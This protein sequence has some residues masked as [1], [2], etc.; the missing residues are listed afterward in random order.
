V[1]TAQ[2]DF[3][4]RPECVQEARRFT[5]ETLHDWD[6][7]VVEWVAGQVVSELCTNAVLHAKTPFRIELLMNS[8]LLT[9]RVHDASAARLPVIR[10]FG[11]Q[12]TTGRG[13]ALVADLSEQWGVD[14]ETGGKTV[15]CTL[16][17]TATGGGH[18]DESSDLDLEALLDSFDEQAGDHDGRGAASTQAL[19]A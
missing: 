11:D 7:D 5:R 16:A 17:L 15:W 18:G 8:S 10:R 1:R 12:A 6:A 13:L 3:E 4:A 14:R 9:V 19:A 2:A